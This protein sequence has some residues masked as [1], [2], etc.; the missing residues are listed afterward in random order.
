MYS[1]VTNVLGLS[2]AIGTGVAGLNYLGPVAHSAMS[3]IEYARDLNE[4]QQVAAAA[5]IADASGGSTDLVRD[6]YL[7]SMPPSWTF[8]G[9]VPEKL[10]ADAAACRRIDV[11]AA[12]FSG[13]P[14]AAASTEC[15]P[16][17][18]TPSE[19]SPACLDGGRP[20]FRMP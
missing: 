4:G 18:A 6:G 1:V 19:A 17:P 15:P 11:V 16:C 3:R 12:S 7:S 9:G 2:L 8:S 5:T 10:L 14:A 20:V 13:V